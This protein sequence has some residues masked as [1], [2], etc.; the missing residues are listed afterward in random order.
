MSGSNILKRKITFFKKMNDLF[1]NGQMTDGAFP[2]KIN[3]NLCLKNRKYVY[4]I[5]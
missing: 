4:S 1:V 2:K 5:Q 3:E